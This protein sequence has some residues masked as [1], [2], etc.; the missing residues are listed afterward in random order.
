MAW[1]KLCCASSWGYFKYVQHLMKSLFMT[2][3]WFLEHVLLTGVS[4]VLQ[5]WLKC[6]PR[7]KQHGKTGNWSL[8]IY[9]RLFKIVT[10][11][12][13]SN[14]KWSPKTI[15]KTT[16]EFYVDS[17]LPESELGLLESESSAFTATPSFIWCLSEASGWWLLLIFYT[18]HCVHVFRFLTLHS[19]T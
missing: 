12:I 11:D 10:V 1:Y 8:G 16:G 4:W 7:S 13:L 6:V 5:L 2:V 9:L 17:R 18:W 3:T 19:Q 15:Q 14:V